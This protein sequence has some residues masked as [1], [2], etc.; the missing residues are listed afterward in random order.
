MCDSAETYP[1]FPGGM[2]AH[3]WSYLSQFP[4]VSRTDSLATDSR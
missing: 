3:F 1:G 2:D 4:L